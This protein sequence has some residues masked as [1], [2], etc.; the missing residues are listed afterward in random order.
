ILQE[1][2]DLLP[3]EINFVSLGSQSDLSPAGGHLQGADDIDALMVLEAGA[4]LRRLPARRP[5]PLQRADQREAAFVLKNQ[6]PPKL[7]PLFL[8]VARRS[9][10]NGQ[11][12]GRRAAEPRAGASDNSSQVA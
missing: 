6:R 3:R 9:V 4:C 10:S 7:P 1:G 12:L 2:D 8:Y 11:S 5:G